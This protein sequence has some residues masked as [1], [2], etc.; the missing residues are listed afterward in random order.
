MPYSAWD[1]RTALR[2]SRA[3][4][5]SLP[6]CIPLKLGNSHTTARSKWE[7]SKKNC[8]LHC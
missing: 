3:K 6:E 7:M 5:S 8:I 1:N 4:E 2:T